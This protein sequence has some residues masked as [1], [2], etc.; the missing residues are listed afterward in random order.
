MDWVSDTA[1]QL[2]SALNALNVERQSIEKRITKEAS[3]LVDAQY[4]DPRLHPVLVIAGTGWHLGVMG[5]VAARLVARYQRPAVCLAVDE[6]QS[7]REAPVQR[8][9]KLRV[10]GCRACA[11][12]MCE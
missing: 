12:C 7:M 3:A 8:A 5:I 11:S 10:T 9:D 1:K 6:K 4:R 2:A